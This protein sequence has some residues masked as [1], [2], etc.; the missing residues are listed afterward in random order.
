[1]DEYPAPGLTADWLNAW[2]AAI[3]V[4]VLLPDARLRWTDDPLPKAVFHL[5]DD[6]DSLPDLI[7]AALPT[8]EDIGGWVISRIDGKVRSTSTY[9]GLAE[10]ARAA[11]DDTL[12]M[13]VTDLGD[14]ATDGSLPKA[15]FDPPVPAGRTLSWRLS[16][17]VE[18]IS[19]KSE[20]VAATLGGTA[21]RDGG[22]GLGFDYRRIGSGTDSLVEVLAFEGLRLF[23]V[24]GDGHR[25]H[26]RGWS[27][28]VMTRGAFR[29]PVWKEALDRWAIDAILDVASTDANRV[30][31][32]VTAMFGSVPYEVTSIANP[33]RGYASERIW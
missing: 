3:G 19:P 2:L 16:R 14:A 20:R 1:M 22:N 32:P 13:T 15:P 11:R 7:A 21:V 10:A 5:P 8:V 17:A 23:P 26:Q 28:G 18:S 31:S 30:R 25:A 4:T 9:R 33:T 24:R 12:S 6:S 27:A 29:W